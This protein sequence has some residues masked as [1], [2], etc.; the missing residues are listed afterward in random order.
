MKETILVVDDENT[1]LETLGGY[2]K[3]Q[4]FRVLKAENGKKALALVE[5]KMVDLILTDMRMPEMLGLDLL[6]N[7]KMLNPEITVVMMTAFGSVEDAVTAMKEGADDYLQKPIDLDQLDMIIKRVLDKK[8]LLS[9]NQTLKETLKFRF[10]FRNLISGSPKMD[11]V[12]SMAGRA[13]ASKAT[14]LLRG[15]SGTGKEVIAK[16]IH[17]ASPRQEKPFVAVNVAAV[18][19]NLIESEFFG[20]EKGAFT[21]AERMRKGRFETANGGTLFID[22]IGDIPVSS[23]VKLLRVLQERTFER[24][25]GN[26]TI[27][28]D[29]RVIAATNQNLESLIRKGEFREDLFY[30]LNVVTINIPP[31]RERKEEIPLFIDHFIRKYGK[32][33]GKSVTSLSKETMDILMK[34]N[35]PGNVRELENIIQ[36]AVVLTQEPVISTAALSPQVMTLKGESDIKEPGSLTE[37]VEALENYLI[38]TAIQNS[39]GNQSE[40]ARSLGIT[41]RNLRYKMKK[42]LMK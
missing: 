6:K 27:A 25:G 32:E 18:S 29:V 38:R 17:L 26:E 28:F 12:L 8:R 22:E 13:A 16:A 37:K 23:Q 5:N 30:R 40:A 19:E 39:R 31:L 21:G 20:H 42:Y 1:Q 7:V 10:D 24:V 33:E 11:D 35:Y 34:Y 2:L 41:E 3:K 9:E 14:V 4:A 36:R 15:E